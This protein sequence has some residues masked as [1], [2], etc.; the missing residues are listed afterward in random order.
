MVYLTRDDSTPSI[1]CD[2]IYLPFELSFLE[3][4]SIMA[5]L[6]VSTKWQPDDTWEDLREDNE[7]E[8]S[9]MKTV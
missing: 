8:L 4:T 9:K 7:M 2:Y 1:Q 3:H 5:R 6:I